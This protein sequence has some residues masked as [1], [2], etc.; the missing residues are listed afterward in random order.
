MW[1]EIKGYEGLYEI[2]E[3]A[4]VR[5]MSGTASDGRR[6]S[7]HRVLSS[8]TAKGTDYIALWKDGERRTFMLHKLYAQAFYMSEKE[9]CRRLYYGFRGDGQAV[10]N[11]KVIL[12]NNLKELEEREAAGEDHHD[13]I[14]Y[15]K[16][17][18]EEMKNNG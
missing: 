9:A 11:V 18:L 16:Q 4:M 12:M 3:Q 6:T 2:N 10:E 14:L 1:R 17:F 15:M 5:R 7:A 13:E 8:K